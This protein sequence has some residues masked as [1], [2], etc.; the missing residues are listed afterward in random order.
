MSSKPEDMLEHCEACGFELENGQ[1]G[2]CDDCQAISLPG[3]LL[4]EACTAI[5]SFNVRENIGKCRYVVNFHDG[6]KTHRDGSPFF[7]VHIVSNKRALTRV[8]K[9]LQADGYAGA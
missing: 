8:V 1:I 7:D 6:V 9:A 2:Q 4:K 5:K 3:A